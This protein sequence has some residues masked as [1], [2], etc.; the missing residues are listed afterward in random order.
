MHDNVMYLSTLS[1]ALEPL[2]DGTPSDV[3]HS[4]PGLL[5]SLNVM[6]S[7]AKYYNSGERMTIFLKKIT[8]QIITNCKQNITTQGK[9]WTQ[10]RPDLIHHLQVFMASIDRGGRCA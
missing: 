4:L 6:H 2:Y 10:D 9:F 7:V 5:K 1:K 3:K 8:N